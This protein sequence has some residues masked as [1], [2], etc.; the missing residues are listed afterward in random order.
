MEDPNAAAIRRELEEYRPLRKWDEL[1]YREKRRLEQ[2]WSRH[3]K[4]V[5]YGRTLT[6]YVKHS[7]VEVASGRAATRRRA[8]AARAAAKAGH[9]DPARVRQGR[10]VGR[11]RGLA[12]SRLRHRGLR[13]RTSGPRCGCAGVRL[14]RDVDVLVRPTPAARRHPLAAVGRARPGAPRAA[15]GGPGPLRRGRAVAQAAARRVAL[16][17]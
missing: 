2:E 11:Q 1:H 3:D 8:Q 16:S 14:A 5:G 13:H 4:F 7:P 10:L 15:G 9:P 6:G 12:G 17:E